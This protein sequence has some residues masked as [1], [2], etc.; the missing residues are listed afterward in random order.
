MKFMFKRTFIRLVVLG[1]LAFTLLFG[2]VSA[3]KAR[4]AANTDGTGFE[5]KA[6]NKR[7]SGEFILETIVG[8]VLFGIK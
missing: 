1:C 7:P 5:T 3:G 8:S 2:L 6:E 4:E